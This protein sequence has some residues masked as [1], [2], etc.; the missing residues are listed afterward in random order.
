MYTYM[1]M[2]IYIYIYIHIY[3]YRGV[4]QTS[5]E[6]EL[7]WHSHAPTYCESHKLI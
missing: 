2:Y 6:K 1:Y 3:I 4:E 7:V 5:C